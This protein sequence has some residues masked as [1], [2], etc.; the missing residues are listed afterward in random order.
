MSM[1]DSKPGKM[2]DDGQHRGSVDEAR[3]N[4]GGRSGGQQGHGQTDTSLQGGQ[5]SQPGIEREKAERG[6]G[7]PA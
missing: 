6:K 3:P 5:G 7:S 1:Q 4:E 2:T